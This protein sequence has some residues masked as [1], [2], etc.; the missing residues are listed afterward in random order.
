MSKIEF[1]VEI[2]PEKK[3]VALA[4]MALIAAMAELD[5]E[6]VAKPR[7][8]VRSLKVVEP[9]EVKP[10]ETPVEEKP[11]RKKTSKKTSPAKKVETEEVEEKIEKEEEAPLTKSAPAG[12]KGSKASVSIED[13]RKL[14][15]D[16]V[17]DNRDAIKAKLE[18]LGASSASTL[19]ES[20]FGEFYSYLETL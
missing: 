16:L 6:D 12:A 11:A 7:V 18:E 13:I 5:L 2:N 10:E 3:E 8:E 9:E 17:R 4:A 15:K 14:M 20:Q 19:E 1:S